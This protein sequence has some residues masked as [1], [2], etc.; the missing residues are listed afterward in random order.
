LIHGKEGA[1]A[2][3]GPNVAPPLTVSVNHALDLPYALGQ[4]RWMDTSAS[5][6]VDIANRLGRMHF[7]RGLADAGKMCAHAW[8]LGHLL[9]KAVFS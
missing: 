7:R 8:Q 6:C 2:L 4:S 9:A 3:F 5:A 1:R